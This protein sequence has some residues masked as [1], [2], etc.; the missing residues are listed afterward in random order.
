MT[1]RTPSLPFWL[2]LLLMSAF[3]AAHQASTLWPDGDGV[4][5]AQ[6]DDDDDDLDDDDELSASVEAGI[7]VSADKMLKARA[8]SST[9]KLRE[10][11]RRAIRHARHADDQNLVYISL[12]RAFAEAR[13][14]RRDQG[15]IDDKLKHL[16]GLTRIEYLFVY[17]DADELVI[18][19]PAE[20]VDTT[21]PHRPAGAATGRP[22]VQLTDL[23]DMLRLADRQVRKIGCSLDPDPESMQRVQA[24]VQRYGAISR[25]E[26]RAFAR[27]LK[28]AM[29]GQNVRLFGVDEASRAAHAFLVADYLM[30]RQALGLA[31][32]PIRGMTHAIT[33]RAKAAGRFWFEPA[34]E[35][36]RQSRDKRVY[37][38]DGARLQVKSGR[39]M[40]QE[41]GAPRKAKAFATNF[42]RHMADLAAAEPAYAD[43]QNLVDLYLLAHLVE[44]DQ[45]DE[46][47]DW[48]WDWARDDQAWRT[49]RFR[50]PE[51]AEP[52]ISFT[53]GS[54]AAGGV[55]IS[56]QSVIDQDKREVD[57]SGRLDALRPELP[58]T[59]WHWFEVDP[60]AAGDAEAP[61]AA[62]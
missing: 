33:P 25:G 3:A 57:R 61:D 60:T 27:D 45:L 55:S 39:L 56:V 6:D 28:D 15:K 26:R 49:P 52:L 48:H 42:T 58:D 31:P 5:W 7:Y 24:V 22:V 10:M 4:V 21:E 34:Y 36:I 13:R 53:S 38:L 23:L 62:E 46:Q 51:T 2:V 17:P 40:F 59:G 41:G 20:P 19:G 35:P 9:E 12:P 54:I 50:V 30:K 37:A 43:L 1:S 18:A 14:Q 44:A 16:A 29:G 8:V 47:A 11:R 32:I